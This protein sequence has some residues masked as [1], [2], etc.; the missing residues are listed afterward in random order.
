MMMTTVFVLVSVWIAVWV[1]ETESEGM[2]DVVTE[3]AVRHLRKD[4]AQP[5]AAPVRPRVATG[6]SNPLERREVSSHRVYDPLSG[7]ACWVVGRCMA[8]S[9]SERNENFCRETG[10]RQELECPRPRDPTDNWVHTKPE[11]ER[12]TRYTP[13]SAESAARPGVAVVKFEVVMTMILAL[14]IAL[15]RR[16]RRKHMSAFD[17]RLEPRQSVGLLGGPAT[18]NKGSD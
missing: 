17:M 13:C 14:S 18:T 16:E 9:D 10:Y 12:Q 2:T 1:P 11:E 6:W 15:L 3:T 8:C 7:L 5:S 4:S